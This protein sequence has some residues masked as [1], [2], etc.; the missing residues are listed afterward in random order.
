MIDPMKLPRLILVGAFILA[1][2]SCGGGG[3]GGASA[4]QT[5]GAAT[6]TAVTWT[7]TTSED[8]TVSAAVAANGTD[9]AGPGHVLQARHD[10]SSG[11]LELVERVRFISATGPPV[12]TWLRTHD[13]LPTLAAP[14]TTT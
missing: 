1:P 2:A 3:G 9:G 8:A 11:D 12:L 13:M 7:G 5:L 4:P 14:M 6:L 10:L